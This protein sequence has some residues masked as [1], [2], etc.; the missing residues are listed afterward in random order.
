MLINNSGLFIDDRKISEMGI[1]MTMQINHFGHFYLTYLLFDKIR[2]AKEGRIINVASYAHT[3][4]SNPNT[5][6][7]IKQDQGEYD[8]LAQYSRSKL[9]NV[10]FTV[11]LAKR[12][13][14]HNVKNVKTVSLHPGVVDSGFYQNTTKWY[15]PLVKTCCCCLFINS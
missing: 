1:E 7:N 4:I 2:Q 14:A 13:E 11:A 3:M 10:Q 12:L 8:Y 6:E 9:A 15:A 5:L